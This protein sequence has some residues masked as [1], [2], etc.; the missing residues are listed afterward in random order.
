MTNKNN[1]GGI[2][3]STFVISSPGVMPFLLFMEETRIE[4]C[5]G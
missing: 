1:L 3:H 2:R 4:K 5:C